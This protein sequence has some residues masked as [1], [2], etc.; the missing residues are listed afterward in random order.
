M[1][2]ISSE[3]VEANDPEDQ[4]QFER[5]EFKGSGG[6]YFRIWIV[7][8]FLTIL[9][10]GV[11]SA[12]AKVRTNK[13][14]LRKTSFKNIELDY[15]ATGLPILIGRLITLFLLSFY[16]ISGLYS[17][18]FSFFS[19]VLLIACLPVLIVKSIKFKAQNTSYRNIRFHFTGDI[20]TFY[21]RM[22][23]AMKW[24]F[25]F[26]LIFLAS[27][28]YFQN[29]IRAMGKTA[30]MSEREKFVTAIFIFNMSF[31]TISTCLS[32]AN[33]FNTFFS[34]V[35]NNLYY[36]GQKINFDDSML[37]TKKELTRPYILAVALTMMSAGL[38]LGSSFFVE[39]SSKESQFIFVIIMI[40]F[41]ILFYTSIILL[42]FYF[43]YLLQR[44]VWNNI[45]LESVEVKNELKLWPYIR[46]NISNIFMMLFT[47]GIAYPWAK[48]R[49]TK[50]IMSA[51]ML[52]VH[53]LDEFTDV[54]FQKQ[55]AV[56]EQM[57][58]GFDVDFDIGI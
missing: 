26:I 3:V 52:K 14:F 36:G 33:I 42:S 45:S 28:F 17:T 30:S 22:F 38:L 16:V 50:L 8:L 21:K 41:V 18:Q 39:S 31:I 23:K 32:L 48:V 19:V 53:D 29:E 57:A 25:I 10:F 2:N 51:R 7:N 55:S 34:F 27:S 9:T 15:H 6:E 43:P 4:V 46:M 49:I 12:W 54:A 24:P 56:F 13:Y 47:F 1:D 20:P 44:Y 5:V 35:F 58:Q 11:Y 40:V 37:K